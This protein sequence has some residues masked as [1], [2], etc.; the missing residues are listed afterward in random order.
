MAERNR[1]LRVLAPLLLLAFTANSRAD[2]PALPPATAI[3]QNIQF[4]EVNLKCE[5]TAQDMKLWI[6]LPPGQHADKS[7]A[8]VFIAPAGSNGLTGMSLADGDRVE[9]L[10]YAAAGFA[11]VAYELTGVRQGLTLAEQIPSMKKFM[12]AHGGV[13]NAK[14]AVDFALARV[15]SVDPKRLYAAGHSSAATVALDVMAADP[16]IKACC[17]Y[18]PLSNLSARYGPILG[19]LA[20]RVPGID[21][22]AGTVS[23]VTHLQEIKDRPILLFTA[24]DDGNVP[25]VNVQEFAG[26][27]QEAGATKTKLVVVDSGGH[28][29]AMI[30]QGIP[31]GIEFLKGVDAGGGR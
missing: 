15:A 20:Q 1:L 10:P 2:F 31:A 24:R 5:A 25:S 4:F 21:T 8:C 27:L 30:A 23:P 13:D 7:L 6:Y 26:R 18:A 17:A 12:A 28:Y 19:A 16:R 14:T 9:H 3:D 29:D 22:F 11:V